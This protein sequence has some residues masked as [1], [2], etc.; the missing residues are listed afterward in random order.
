MDRRSWTRLA[1]SRP[2]GP[3]AIVLLFAFCSTPFL[4]L[5][6]LLNTPYSSITALPLYPNTQALMLPTATTVGLMSTPLP[7]PVI[8]PQAAPDYAFVTTDSRDVVISFYKTTL[9]KIYGSQS[10]EVDLQTPSLTIIRGTRSSLYNVWAME[11]AT[12]TINSMPDGKTHVQVKL[13]ALPR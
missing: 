12:I 11:Q 2:G 9:A 6:S 3:I 1:Y 10:V 7:N 8:L 5:G 13:E 4:V